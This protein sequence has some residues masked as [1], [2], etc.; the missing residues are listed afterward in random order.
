SVPHWPVANNQRPART[1]RAKRCG[2][3]GTSAGRM[4]RVAAADDCSRPVDAGREFLFGGFMA[5]CP[6]AYRERC[7]S[8]M[9]GNSHQ[10]K[11]QAQ[12]E[13]TQ[14]LSAPNGCSGTVGTSERY[15]AKPGS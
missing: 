13:S 12:A 1:P 10:S 9:R 2:V 3:F 14:R 4:A 15:C 11:V 8:V 5:T 6:D 7:R